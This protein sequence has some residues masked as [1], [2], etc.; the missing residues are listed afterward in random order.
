MT[1]A[2][3]D[4]SSNFF[5]SLSI[6]G[7]NSYRTRPEAFALSVLG[8]AAVLGIIIYF[9]SCVIRTPPDLVHRVASLDLPL[10]F[11]GHN[12]GGG[13]GLDPLPASRGNPPRASLD[14]QILPP[15]VVVP[16]EMPKLPVDETVVVAPDVKYPQGGQIGDPA[17]PFARWLSNG[18]GGPGGIGPGCCG[19][20]GDSVGPH[21]GSGP[22]GIYP[23]GKG[24]VTV[25]Q[26]I[27]SPE[28]NFSEEA[29]KSKTQG[30]VL[31]LIVVGPD[32][33]PSNLRVQQSLGMGLD[34]KAIEAVSR[35][36]F[37]PATL[38]GQPVA[39]QIAV[40]VN[41]RLY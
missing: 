35:W 32:G 38:N 30:I 22:P 24:G 26:V 31:L 6:H 8:Q 34:E 12:G 21:V 40:E 2:T 19:G 37:R 15:T 9:T 29:R 11:S 7:S 5:S 25:P 4:S 27:Y 18:S 23:A 13:G 33:K 20:V 16:K 39:T 14:M 10:I 36:K 1:A 3:L 17:S 41:F 28:P